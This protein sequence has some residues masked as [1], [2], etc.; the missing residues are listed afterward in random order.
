MTD[1]LSRTYA[2]AVFSAQG[3]AWVDFFEF[4]SVTFDHPDFIKAV[5]NPNINLAF[6]QSMFDDCGVKYTEEQLN[7]MR[8]LLH[9]KRVLL[10]PKIALQYRLLVKKQ[11]RILP[12]IVK[13]AQVL[14][15]VTKQELI[16]KLEQKFSK[17][18]ELTNYVD[19]SLIGGMVV[20]V[21]DQVWDS[22]VKNNLLQLKKD[23]YQEVRYAN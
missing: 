5:K 8:V 2:R 20:K 16:K 15:A 23:L 1:Q 3:D 17:G 13:S 10:L 21:F 22:S 7:F 19:E 4:F 14:D 6:F 9:F 11:Q 18:I 12:V